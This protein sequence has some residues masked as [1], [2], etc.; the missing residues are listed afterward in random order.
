M[1]P[2]PIQVTIETKPKVKKKERQKVTPNLW[3]QKEESKQIKTALRVNNF[4]TG[5][6][7]YPPLSV[8]CI[9]LLRLR[10]HTHGRTSQHNRDRKL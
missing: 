6:C 7:I 10:N 4:R 8:S 1:P 5:S 9:K 2:W 3:R